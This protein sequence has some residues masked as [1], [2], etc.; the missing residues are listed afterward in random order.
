MEGKARVACL[1]VLLLGFGWRTFTHTLDFVNHGW[2]PYRMGPPVM[3]TFWNAL[4]F[5]DAAVLA[6]L[7]SKWRRTALIAAAV[8]MI[9]DV[10]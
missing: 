6:L 10:G 5:L 3:N 8:L 1:T 9:A 7:L 4:V 2:F